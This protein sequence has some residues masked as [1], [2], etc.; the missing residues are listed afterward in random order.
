[1]NPTEIV[2]AL[3]EKIDS[4]NLTKLCDILEH[5]KLADEAAEAGASSIIVEILTKQK[6]GTSL[7]IEKLEKCRSPQIF[8]TAV[9]KALLTF[10]D[11]K[12][13]SLREKALATLIAATE[14]RLDFLKSYPSFLSMLLGFLKEIPQGSNSNS[15][16]SNNSKSD[17]PNKLLTLAWK[18]IVVSEKYP[19]NILPIL[20]WYIDRPETTDIVAS[21]VVACMRFEQSHNELTKENI[22][23]LL[24]NV[25]RYGQII[26]EFINS[27][28]KSSKNDGILVK[29]LFKGRMNKKIYDF[30]PK[31]AGNKRFVMFVVEN[32]PLKNDMYKA[33]NVYD[34][35]ISNFIHLHRFRRNKKNK[36]K[37]GIINNTMIENDAINNDKNSENEDEEE[38]EEEETS[39]DYPIDDGERGEWRL[40]NFDFFNDYLAHIPEFYSAS[41]Y[42]IGTKEQL[43]PICTIL[44]NMKIDYVAVSSTKLSQVLADEIV[45][46]NDVD[47]LLLLMAASFSIL[48]V[49]QAEEFI[50]IV[51]R[52][53]S[54]LTGS[55]IK[56]NDQSKNPLGMP[57]FLCLAA[58]ANFS[59]SSVNYQIVVPA[60][61]SL[62]NVDS[63]LL[64]EASAKILHDHIADPNVDLNLVFKIFVESF[65]EKII[66]NCVKMAILAFSSVCNRNEITKEMLMEMSKIYST[67][68]MN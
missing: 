40:T 61:A 53:E 43:D 45:K 12:R 58:I 62:V 63:L 48:K 1:M 52:F 35:I 18:L 5:K 67:V 66:D 10:A 25:D 8:D 14:L 24:R 4:D 21:C 3:K 46:Q 64:R 31:V 56:I 68:Q 9:I 42:M 27:S 59:P 6:K 54:F 38:D 65:N 13:Q 16:Q 15:P 19:E 44:M 49:L 7:L 11:V 47:Q 28:K 60:A 55:D 29:L 41:A 51:H 33:V 23:F 57:S 39:D 36:M 20:M 32:L 50:S 17:L 2:N 26:D 22:I 34:Q 30:I 37:N